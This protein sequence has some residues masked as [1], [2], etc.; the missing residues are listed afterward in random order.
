MKRHD[1]AVSR[2]IFGLIFIA[3]GIGWFPLW[4]NGASSLNSLIFVL[5][6]LLI[7]LGTIGLISTLGIGKRGEKTNSTPE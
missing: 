1:F 4:E 3:V 2:L 7:G 6:L 5:P